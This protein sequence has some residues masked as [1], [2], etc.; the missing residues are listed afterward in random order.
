MLSIDTLKAQNKYVNHYNYNDENYNE[1]YIEIE[2]VISK[3]DI[4]VLESEILKHKNVILFKSYLIPVKFC[5]L[6]VKK[7]ITKQ[8]FEKWIGNQVFKVSVFKN[9]KFTPAFILN[10]KLNP[11]A[12]YEE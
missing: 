6:V 8:E 7:E 10:K 2:N 4:E 1:Y 9:F 5:Q 3:K 12:K 11:N